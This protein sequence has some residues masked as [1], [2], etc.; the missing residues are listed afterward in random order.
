[1]YIG[2]THFRREVTISKFSPNKS[3]V[4]SGLS[5]T[6]KS[7]R[8]SD[9]EKKFV[10]DGGTV[11]AIDLDGSHPN[12]I[13]NA[14]NV[15]SARE[16]G[17]PLKIIRP[18]ILRQAPE[19][20][21]VYVSTFA[22]ILLSTSRAGDRQIG[23]LR[24]AIY[25]ALEERGKFHNDF[26]AIEEGLNILGST[27]S[28]GVRDKLWPLFKSNIFRQSSKTLLE[29]NINIISLNGLDCE[30][31]KIIAEIFLRALWNQIRNSISKNRIM[32]VVDEFQNMPL[33]KKSTI[34]EMM[35]ESRK[36]NVNML[37]STQS[38][39]N[40]TKQ[41]MSAIDQAAVHMYFR[42]TSSEIK[43]ISAQ[44]DPEN[45]EKISFMLKKLWLGQSLVSGNIE[46]N[47]KSIS[48][49]II[50]QTDFDR[51]ENCGKIKNV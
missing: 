51:T 7:Q 1:M 48:Y 20:V 30:L 31:K 44:I 21:A 2:M 41:A 34:F 23:V 28:L 42:P 12:Y 11:V 26:E 45:K 10:R 6:G 35:R 40:F 9:I 46:V 37:L 13:L 38:M 16:D 15:I 5:G 47:N 43:K 18:E 50:I 24:E 25:F 29:K 14:T 36:Y 8:I 39:A 27:I 33:G 49:P 17:I 19:D 22:E 3:I 32:V 4:I